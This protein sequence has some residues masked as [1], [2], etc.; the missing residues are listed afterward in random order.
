MFNIQLSHLEPG[1]D[2]RGHLDLSEAPR[3]HGVVELV[4]PIQDGVPRVLGS[5]RH[6]KIRFLLMSVVASVLR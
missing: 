1:L 6:L 3:P 5:F 2:M 4:Q